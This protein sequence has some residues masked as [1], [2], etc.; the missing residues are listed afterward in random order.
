MTKRKPAT[1]QQPLHPDFIYRVDSDVAIAVVGLG[2]SQRKAAI[3]RG[4]LPPPLKLTPSGR[5]KGWLGSQLIELQRKRLAEAEATSRA[6][7]R[8]D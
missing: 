7:Q 8:N 1:E 5:A 4:E 6:S 3:D 2:P